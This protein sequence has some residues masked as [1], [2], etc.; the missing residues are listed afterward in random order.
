M[1]KYPLLL[2]LNSHDSMMLAVQPII[3]K[4]FE[5]SHRKHEK[6]PTRGLRVR[7]QKELLDGCSFHIG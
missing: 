2:M 6:T 5:Q 3:K 1:Y 4:I 7:N